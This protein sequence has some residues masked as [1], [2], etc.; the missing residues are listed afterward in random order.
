MSGEGLSVQLAARVLQVS[1]SGYYLWTN[2]P[3]LP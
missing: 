1:A 3:T 2:Q